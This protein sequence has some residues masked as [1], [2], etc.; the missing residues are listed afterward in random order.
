MS[1]QYSGGQTDKPIAPVQHIHGAYE[2]TTER[3]TTLVSKYKPEG[4]LREYQADVR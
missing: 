1:W 4:Q 2:Q 3:F